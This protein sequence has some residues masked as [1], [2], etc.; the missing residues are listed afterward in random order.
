MTSTQKPEPKP[1]PEDD[2]SIFE[3]LEEILLTRERPSLGLEAMRA[4]GTLH[5]VPELLTLP[6]VQQN[7]KWHPEGDVW[8]HTLMVVDQAV[9]ERTLDPREDRLLMWSA[10]CHDLGKPLCTV[11]V[12]GRWRSPGHDVAG[13]A[14]TRALL[15]RLTPD[16][17]LIEPVCRLVHDHLAP[18]FFMEEGTSRAGI[19]R[20]VSR[21]GDVSLELLVR[22]GRA[23][24]FGRTTPE[25][26]RR[27]YPS[28]QWLLEQASLIPVNQP[29]PPPPLMMGRHL[30][31]LGMPPGPE[32]GQL[33]RQLHDA[34]LA[35][36]FDDVEGGLRWLRDFYRSQR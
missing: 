2:R 7:P 35:G 36:H 4:R 12:E 11:F 26:L 3:E 18:H 33:L 21:L 9:R 10:L 16:E 23:D 19:R 27:E 22:L 31:A 14:P 1:E 20:L 6:G 29:Q 5:Q 8:I 17:G 32:M 15:S 30:V 25:A 13:V 34:Q 24:S 28:G